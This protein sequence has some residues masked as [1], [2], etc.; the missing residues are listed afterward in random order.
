MKKTTKTIKYRDFEDFLAEEHAKDY[1]GLD[2]DMPDNFEAWLC[3][4]D[5]QELIDYADKYAEAILDQRTKEV[6]GMMST[7]EEFLGK[8]IVEEKIIDNWYIKSEDLNNRKEAIL[9]H[10]NIKDEQAK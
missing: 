3:D 7:D 6:I 10:F 9:K 1:C 8:I 4:L 2:D 5:N